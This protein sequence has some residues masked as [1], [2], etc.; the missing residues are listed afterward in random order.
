M[1]AKIVR[2]APRQSATRQKSGSRESRR[3]SQQPGG[4]A[5]L[6][7]KLVEDQ[8]AACLAAVALDAVDPAEIHARAP[9]RFLQGNSG[10]DEVFGI[11]LDVKA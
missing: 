7:P 3:F 5:E 4:V 11:L 9:S 2:L 6:P 1:T 8:E 10:A